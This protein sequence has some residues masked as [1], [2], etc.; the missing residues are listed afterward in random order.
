MKAS[1]NP[2]LRM[3]QVQAFPQG[4]EEFRVQYAHARARGQ[5]AR[6]AAQGLGVSEGASLA[7]HAA[8]LMGPG[9]AARCGT[10][11]TP[12]GGDWG[13]ILQGL[14][15]CGPLMALTRNE[16]VVH[17]KTG[18]YRRVSVNGDM[19]LA[20]GVEIDLRL[21]LSQW[22][23]GFH[24]LERRIDGG[25]GEER[26]S[27]QFYDRHGQAVHKVHTR[28]QTDVEALLGLV[29]RHAD[30]SR[31]LHFDAAPRVVAPPRPDALIDRTGLD[32]AW[33][34]MQDT[35][36]FFGLLK[37]FEV[38]RQ[39]SFRLMAGRH[40]ERRDTGAVNELL[41]QAA[42]EALPIM[43]FVGN[44]GCIQIHTGPVSR[45]QRMGPWLN[46]MD[47][48]FNLHLREDHIADVW[49]VTKPTSDGPVTSIEAFAADGELIAMFFGER[50]PGKP[51]LPAWRDL[52]H[53]LPRLKA[54]RVAA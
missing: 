53:G 49:L 15:A 13:A 48:G 28:E 8:N 17:E 25:E 29:D 39:Q 27:L 24:V 35:H 12:L 36:E 2:E 21:F 34:A 10:L 32:A 7:F 19:G 5:R 33:S 46:V 14:E 16:H 23:Q 1:T 6:D 44:P 20:L 11:A 37:K 54:E 26:H 3:T 9:E 42:G 30:P 51:E 31:S 43:V 22:A 18:V 52:A 47:P 38:E 41:V 45:I 50:K 4:A 40:A